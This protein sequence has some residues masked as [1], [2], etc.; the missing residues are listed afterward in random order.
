[1]NH[2]QA[3]TCSLIFGAA[4]A[5]GAFGFSSVANAGLD[6]SGYGEI[7]LKLVSVN[8]PNCDPQNG[9]DCSAN[10]QWS[11]SS[12]GSI[13]DSVTSSSGSGIA[14]TFIDLFPTTSWAIG[15]EYLQ[16]A[17]SYGEAGVSNPGAGSASSFTWTDF[18]INVA[19][20]FPTQGQGGE[21]H[22]LDF[23]FAYGGYL[24]ADLGFY[25]PALPIEDGDAYAGIGLWDDFS[26]VFEDNTAVFV[27]GGTSSYQEFDGSLTFR[28]L[29]G[30]MNTLSG[31]VDTDGSAISVPVPPTFW[32]IGLGLLG[33]VSLRRT[34]KQNTLANY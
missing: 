12:G 6:Y 15:D 11:V 24:S 16:A 17:E 9:G 29:A 14:D 34:A 13:F 25:P 33:L 7:W 27:G 3:R 28:L 23:T 2:L 20:L 19:N 8:N 22:P 10:G 30:E 32:L 26:D 21:T 18:Y 31:Y 4:I 5:V 1:M